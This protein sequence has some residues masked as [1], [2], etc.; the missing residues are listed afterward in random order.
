MSKICLKHA[1]RS[2]PYI[3]SFSPQSVKVMKQIFREG[4]A[5]K[6]L[7]I[8]RFDGSQAEKS[9]EIDYSLLLYLRSK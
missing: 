2:K 7:K 9:A 4:K 1:T 8:Q 3:V 6:P 5:R